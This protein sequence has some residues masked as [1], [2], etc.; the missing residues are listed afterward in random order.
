MVSF[1]RPTPSSV[2]ISS[3]MGIHGRLPIKLDLSGNYALRD[4]KGQGKLIVEGRTYSVNYASDI[5]KGKYAKFTINAIHPERRIQGLLEG[6]KDTGEAVK[7]GKFEVMWDADNDPSQKAG[8]TMELADKVNPDDI[9]IGGMLEVFTPVKE[10][11]HLKAELRF[12]NSA[13]RILTVAETVLGDKRK[14]YSGKFLVKRP[15]TKDSF[16]G[17][18]SLKMPFRLVRHVEVSANHSFD[19]SGKLATAFKGIVNQDFLDMGVSGSKKGDLLV[20]ILE[21]AAFFRSSI[22]GAESFRLTFNHKDVSGRYTSQARM[23][24]NGDQY[25]ADMEADFRK[26]HVQVML[27]Q[28]FSFFSVCC[29]VLLLIYVGKMLLSLNSYYYCLG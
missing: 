15:I 12:E 18:A 13:S 23:D 5:Q 9:N 20:R 29:L 25:S 19:D 6:G 3:E 26:V 11:Q 28:A 10:Y 17:M 16:R 14:E 7:R 27:H 21:G 22:P 4:M 2:D 1:K 24:V 8:V